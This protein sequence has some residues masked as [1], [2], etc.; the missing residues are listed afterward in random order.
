MASYLAV[1]LYNFISGLLS[2]APSS[3]SPRKTIRIGSRKSKLALVQTDIVRDALKAAHP[4]L[5]FEVIAM[6]TTGDN[7]QTKPLYSFGAKALW[8]QELEVL[9]LEG[10]LD[11]IVHSLKGMTCPPLLPPTSTKP[12]EG[13][14]L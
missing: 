14:F 6:A 12:K 9:L 5:E 8:T 4:D 13:R 10:K 7:N 1:C 2:S 3:S 11:M